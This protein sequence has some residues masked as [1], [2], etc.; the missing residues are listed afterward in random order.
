VK[1][2]ILGGTRF[3]GKALAKSLSGNKSYIVDI[4]SKRKSKLK[5]INKQYLG[6][7]QNN[8][9][10]STANYDLIIDFIS[11]EKIHVDN[12]LK[13]FNFNLYLYIS[14]MWVDKKNKYKK[15]SSKNFNPKYLSTTSKKYINYKLKIESLLKKRIKKKL[16]IIRL[17]IIFSLASPRIKYYF[18][19]IFYSNNLIQSKNF[20]YTY[21]YYS[22]LNSIVSFFN[23]FI[24]NINRYKK[25]TYFVFSTFVSMHRFVKIITQFL[26]KRIHVN[27]Y[28]KLFLLKNYKQYLHTDPFINE[29]LINFSNK[30]L[31]KLKPLSNIRSLIFANIKKFKVNA[32]NKYLS[33]KEKSFINKFTPYEKI[34]L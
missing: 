26:R 10:N 6:N 24:Q 33:T 11:R 4:F 18:D 3:I 7:L 2:L 16:K 23:R 25:Q 15:N 27:L 17:P 12:V 1:I 21:L 5:K 30:N 8:F 29:Y 19:R 20:N 14:T 22:E 28:S 34:I 13:N 31:I 9:I 32:K